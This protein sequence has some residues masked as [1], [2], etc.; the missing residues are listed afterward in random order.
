MLLLFT[1]HVHIVVS[2]RGCGWVKKTFTYNY[3]LRSTHSRNYADPLTSLE[4]LNYCLA[5][6]M[7]FQRN[8]TINEGIFHVRYIDNHK[9][10]TSYQKVP[11]KYK[12]TVGTN[13]ILFWSGSRAKK[14][15]LTQHVYLTNILADS[16]VRESPQ[17][18]HVRRGG[19]GG[20][21]GRGGRNQGRDRAAAP[22]LGG[23]G[24]GQDQVGGGGRRR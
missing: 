7:I 16:K 1:Y 3:R 24:R 2:R 13:L 6:V 9:N 18:I 8:D 14:I 15:Y 22:N 19:C 21:G 17:Q 20:V 4:L 10:W 11:Y 12:K 23:G 5:L